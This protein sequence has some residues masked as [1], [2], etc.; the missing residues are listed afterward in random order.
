MFRLDESGE[1]NAIDFGDDT[2]GSAYHLTACDDALVSIGAKDIMMFDGES[3]TR[4]A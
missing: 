3:W 1:I 2:P 4:I